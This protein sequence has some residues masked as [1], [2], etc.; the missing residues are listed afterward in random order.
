MQEK[1]NPIISIIVP[2]YNTENYLRRC[3]D[4]ILSQSFTDFELLLINDGSKDSS[5][6]ICDEYFVKD[7]RVR[8]FHKENGGISSVRDMGLDKALGEWITFVDSDD[9][10]KPNYLKN[11]LL[12]DA[13]LIV[14]AHETNDVPTEKIINDMLFDRVAWTTWGKLYKIEV[15][16]KC[17]PFSLPR[18]L[19]I[20]EDLISNIIYCNNINKVKYVENNGYFYCVNN[21]S[22]TK[23]RKWTIDYE[24]KFLSYVKSLLADNKKYSAGYWL[25]TL[26]AIKN[27][28]S[29]GV[30]VPHSC[31]MYKYVKAHVYDVPLGFGD[32]LV[33]LCPF[34][35]LTMYLLNVLK[36]R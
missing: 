23:T 8:V 27:L 36:K 29:N 1:T 16:K 24:T 12:D 22:L 35:R 19:N 3:V 5:G 2:V 15:L 32:K 13:Q 10:I 9:W 6:K 14:C 30:I 17:N 28:Y 33:L 26:R 11:F 34:A 18:E 31:I 7:N 25:L 20:G 21:D 4:S